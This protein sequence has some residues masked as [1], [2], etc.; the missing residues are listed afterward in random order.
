MK[1]ITIVPT[2]HVADQSLKD[3]RKAIEENKPDCV[4]V[5]L[6]LNRYYAM[7]TEESVSNTEMIKTFGAMNF[8]IYWFMKKLQKYLGNKVGIIPG[9]EMM[10]AVE[11][12][13]EHK[14][15]VAFIDRDIT[16][17]F[18]RM[19]RIPKT[20]K[21]KMIWLLIKGSLG[22]LFSKIYKGKYTLDLTKTPPKE[23]INEAMALLKKELPAFYKIF[24]TERDKYMI[25]SIKNLSKEFDNVV[26]VIGAGHYE[27][28]MKKL[29]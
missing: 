26:V 5:E 12:A 13:S 19:S 8:I 15:K 20:E 7:K 6:D 3:V 22:I 28:I 16:L 25:S 10:K 24:V 23:I 29:K 27:G 18:M 4:A 11:I 14:I 9:S 2:S 17:T 1:E 21:L